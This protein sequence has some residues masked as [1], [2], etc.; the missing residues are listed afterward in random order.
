LNGKPSVVRDVVVANA[1]LGVRVAGKTKD[2][3]EG[4]SLA[5]ESIDSG[6]AMA[7]LRALIEQSNRA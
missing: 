5:M 6:R 4:T 3:R 1:S 2:I 7:K